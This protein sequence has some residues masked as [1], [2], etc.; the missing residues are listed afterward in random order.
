MS[1]ILWRPSEDRVKKTN[2]YKFMG[3]VNRRFNRDFTEYE[4]LYQWSV[5]DIPNFWA[6]MWEFGEISASRHYDQV[7][8]DPG[9]MPGAKWFPGARLNFAENLLRYRDGEPA[10]IFHGEDHERRVMT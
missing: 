7:I 9:K 1:R 5:E 2:M 10:L 3:F 8:D 6:S 4:S